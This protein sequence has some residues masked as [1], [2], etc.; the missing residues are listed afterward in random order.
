MSNNT[1]ADCKHLETKETIKE[2]IPYGFCK[3]TKLVLIAVQ[4]DC[5][6]YDQQK[7]FV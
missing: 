7:G 3:E 2:K 5:V 1:C 6:F 4:M